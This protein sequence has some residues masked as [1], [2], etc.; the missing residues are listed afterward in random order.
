MT[1]DF[2]KQGILKFVGVFKT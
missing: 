1:K 2:M